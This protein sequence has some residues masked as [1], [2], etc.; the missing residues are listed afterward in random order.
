[1]RPSNRSAILDAAIRVIHRDGVTGVTFDSVAAESGITRG[2]LLYHFPSREVLLRA[3]HEHLAEEWDT[4]MARHAGKTSEE[5][6]STE[7]FVAYLQTCLQNATR[8]ELLLMLE[9]STEPELTAPWQAV[10]E[11]WAPP[12][13]PNKADPEALDL[14]IAR[15]AADGLWIHEALAN[16]PLPRDLRTR[17]IARLTDECQHSAKR[18]RSRAKHQAPKQRAPR[19]SK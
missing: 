7:R 6:S 10:I 15:L 8:A 2:G 5:A 1:M 14:F 19:S 13:P 16:K 3:I 17:I 4:S 11:K 18:A 9:G 12:P